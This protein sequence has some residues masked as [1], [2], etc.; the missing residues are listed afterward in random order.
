MKIYIFGFLYFITTYRRI[1]TF[2]CSYLEPIPAT[3]S[4]L[5]VF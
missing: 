1:L 5:N 3:N 4:S 2:D